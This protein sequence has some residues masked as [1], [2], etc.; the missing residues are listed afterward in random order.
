MYAALARLSW[1]IEVAAER[2]LRRGVILAAVVFFVATVPLRG[3]GSWINKAAFLILYLLFML[4]LFDRFRKRKEREAD[5][6]ASM[7][8]DA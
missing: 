1:F 6:M 2:F 4:W 3:V 7:R 5:C 8:N